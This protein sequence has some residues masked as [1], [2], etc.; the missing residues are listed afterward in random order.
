MIVPRSERWTA[1]IMSALI[2]LVFLTPAA[3]VL[4]AS[5][6]GDGGFSAR[7]YTP[8]WTDARPW[9]LFANSMAVASGAAALATLVGTVIALT[10][11]T[12]K[13]HA[14]ISLLALG[15]APLLIPPY[16][17]ATAWIEWAGHRGIIRTVFT[18]SAS[19]SAEWFSLYGIGGVVTVL[20]ASYYPVVMIM[21]WAGLA[22]VG[23]GAVEAGWMQMSPGRVLWRVMLPNARAGIATGAFVVFMVA[24]ANYSVP[25]LLLVD[26][27]PVEVHAQF[28]AFYDTQRA[29]AA[30]VPMLAAA[31]AGAAWW[32]WYV[33]RQPSNSDSPIGA[34]R[35][36][37]GI[38]P[39][40]MLLAIAAIVTSSVFPLGILAQRAGSWHS[41]TEVLATARE[42]MM[43]SVL[44]AAVTAT[45]LTAL[46][47]LM[48]SLAHAS[49]GMRWANRGMLLPFVLSGPLY[50]VGLILLYNRPGIPGVLYDSLAIVVLGCCA[51]FL[52]FAV[53]VGG[54]A[55]NTIS[56]SLLDAAAIAG[57]PWWR[58][59]LVLKAPM[60]AP[61]A[62]AAWGIAFVLVF[63]EADAVT[64]LAPPGV[65]PLPAR[66]HSLMHYG[67]SAYVAAL[68][69]TVVAML[70][71]AAGVCVFV[72]LTVRRVFHERYRVS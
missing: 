30:V 7:A 16:V 29:S 58:Q 28:S 61:W 45:L 8:L 21:A 6:H 59:L 46:G 12:L 64:L 39:L 15:A 47:W 38:Q 3:M 22:R 25:S 31:A 26:V 67:P 51:R 55:L 41:Y 48:A 62:V 72:F 54:A 27:Y 23:R 53:Y 71:F 20:A 9:R 14:G 18:G 40:P 5:F 50:A 17:A 52:F 57:Q 69:L 37:P 60:T 33:R 35:Y 43:T 24:L 44:L 10:A 36:R 70:M 32:R 66:L 2:A 49:R 13:P 11:C 63:S 56:P 4:W 19:G 34:T 1:R 68:S 42:E 65:T